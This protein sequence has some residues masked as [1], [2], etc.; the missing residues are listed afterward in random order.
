M[1][2]V[3]TPPRLSAWLATGLS[4]LVA[5][6]ASN[7]GPPGSAAAAQGSLELNQGP[8]N[9]R[10]VGGS[11]RGTVVFNGQLVR[12][13]IGGVG[14]NGAAVAVLQTSG[15]VYH[16][17]D[18]AGFPGTYRKAPAASVPGQPDGGL[19]LQNERGLIMHL[20]VPPQGRMPDI[21]N[22]ALRIVFG[23]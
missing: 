18:L 22:D 15:Q 11:G 14:L 8:P 2:A 7:R 19:W 21:G 10:L 12:F 17:D 6:C 20:D 16:L 4:L 1:P 5:A 9:D 13:D 23:G 3:A